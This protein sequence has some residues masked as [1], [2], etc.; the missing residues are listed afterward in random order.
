MDQ[1]IIKLS[2]AALIPV[3]A[4]VVFYLIERKNKEKIHS[5]KRTELVWQ[6]I[7]GIV[8]GGIAVLGN[9]WG[10]PMNGAVVNCRDGAV[11][12][13]GFLFGG[14]AGILAG[15]IGGVERWLAVAWGAGTFTKVA[16]SVSTVL[17]GFYAAALRRFMFDNKKPG[18]FMSFACGLVMEVV[19]LTMVFLTNLAEVERAASVVKSCTVPMLVANSLTVLLASFT[20][21]FFSEDKNK[22]LQIKQRIS[23]TIQRWLLVVIIFAFVLTSTFSFLLQTNLA[24]NDAERLLEIVLN[25]IAA[26][27]SDASDA[28]MLITAQNIK[29]D[30][31]KD[32][33]ENV[34]KRYGVSEIDVIDKDGII[35]QSTTKVFVGFDM[36]SGEQA[37][38]FLSILDGAESVVQEY[39]PISYNK[40]IYRKY[41]G[42]PYKD[43]I[44]QIGLDAKALQDNLAS[45]IG[46]RAK[47][48]RVGKDGVAVIADA[49]GR[50]VSVTETYT[51]DPVSTRFVRDALSWEQN[52]VIDENIEE[53]PCYCMSTKVEGYIIIAAYPVAEAM[54]NRTVATYVNSFMEVLIF[55]VLFALVYFLIK[56]LVVSQ[57]NKINK[58]LGE[59]T[60]GDLDVT[61]DVRTNE[62]FASLSDDINHTVDTMKELIAEA[63]ARIDKE[64]EFA[65]NIQAS[66]LPNVFPA[67]PQRPE[68]DIFA[69]MDTAKEVGGDFYDFYMSEDGCLNF[70]IADVSGK[71]IP[72]ALFMMRSKVQLKSLTENG[73]PVNEVFTIGNEHLCEGNE[74]DMFVTAWQGKLNPKTGQVTFANAGHNPPLVRHGN[75]DFEYLRSRAGMVLAGID[76]TVYKLQELQLQP[77]DIIY[78]YTDGVTEATDANEELYGEDR[79]LNLLNNVGTDDVQTICKA[80]KADL[81][82]FVGEAEQFDDI[83]MVAVR[84]LGPTAAAEIAQA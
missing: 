71:G 41:A 26:D 55:A 61:V 62:E 74:A 65:R 9:E 17:A 63:A 75:G 83:T 19:H 3:A 35:I 60:R 18:W 43:G 39:G 80:V 5:N 67:F 16:C 49:Q 82:L 22:L 23:D 28:S 58:S 11:L 73:L 81:A 68:F 36:H 30:L 8:F 37:R 57:I 4:A 15:L 79:L 78:L 76:I 14:P 1:S 54:N 48:R 25:D 10:I 45:Q 69:S 38:E 24:E 31:A 42:I 40:S 44:L 66:A 72:A 32:N 59:I 34:A 53:T 46:L 33:L 27:I 50:I 84:Y 52:V 12:T 70:L 6:V 51:G 29:N 13:A 47:N 7:I 56:Y 77:G 2:I 21:S 64:L 20:L